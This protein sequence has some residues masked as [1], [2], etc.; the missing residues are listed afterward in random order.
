MT[1][2]A[3]ACEIIAVIYICS[4]TEN[5]I[6]SSREDGVEV[7]QKSTVCEATAF[8]YIALPSMLSSQAEKMM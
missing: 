3:T 4:V 5:A 2:K 7:T 6:F 8:I 1:Q